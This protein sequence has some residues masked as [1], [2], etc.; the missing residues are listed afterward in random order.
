MIRS[1]YKHPLVWAVVIAVLG[2]GA[3]TMVAIF[4][5]TEHSE[6]IK[7]VT[8]NTISLFVLLAI[9]V[10]AFIYAKEWRVMQQGLRQ[11]DEMIKATQR[12][13]SQTDQMIE[14]METQLQIMREQV[15]ASETSFRVA[16]EG[17]RLVEKNS[18]YANRAYI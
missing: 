2:F 12:G 1:S 3:L 18:I 11:T 4:F 10:Q 9:V 5:V 14:K 8:V 15:I 13:L 6:R 17:S 16:M 7:F